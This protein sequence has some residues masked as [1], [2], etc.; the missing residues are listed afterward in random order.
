MI[1]IP[2]SDEADGDNTKTVDNRESDN[3]SNGYGIETVDTHET[4]DDS[5]HDSTLET[6][7]DDQLNSITANQ[8]VACERGDEPT[9]LHKCV[10][11]LQAIHILDGC[12]VDIGEKEGCGQKRICMSCHRTNTKQQLTSS[13]KSKDSTSQTIKE[14]NYVDVWK[15]KNKK[16]SSKANT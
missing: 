4:T 14:M 16:A 1:G 7:D 8:C 12:S 2:K 3:E 6:N 10:S 9:G 5:D 13:N 11:C 15:K